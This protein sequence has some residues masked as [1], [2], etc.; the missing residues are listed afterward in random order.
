[1]AAVAETKGRDLVGAL[2]AR[3]ATTGPWAAA[4]ERCWG[5]GRDEASDGSRG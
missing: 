5:D 3:Q 4:G 2:R 1:M